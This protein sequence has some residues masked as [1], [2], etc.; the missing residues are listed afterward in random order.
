MTSTQ[1]PECG[2]SGGRRSWYLIASVVTVVTSAAAQPLPTP[3]Q[4]APQHVPEARPER[5]VVPAFF[6]SEG[7]SFVSRSSRLQVRLEQSLVIFK[8]G[9]AAVT[10]EFS[11]PGRI[12]R[13]EAGRPASGWANLMSG[14]DRGQWRRELPIVNDVVYR[15]IYEGINLH[16]L[17]GSGA[18]KSEFHVAAGA[19]P[20]RIRMRYRGA[21]GV[22][23]AAGGELV[24]TAGSGEMREEAPVAYQWIDGSP[25]AVASR[26]RLEA[27][28]TVGFE[29]GPFDAA[30]GLII[31]PVMN[32][33]SF[34]G[35]SRID[36]ATSV[37]TDS[38]GNVYVAGWSESSDL[39]LT[40]PFGTFRGS[41]D[42]FVYKLNAAG[43]SVVYA[44][45]LGGSGDDRAQ[46]IAVDSLGNAWV[47]GYTTSSNFPTVLP[48]QGSRSG[49][50]DVFVARINA[51]GSG[52]LMSTYYGGGSNDEANAIAVDSFNQAYV[53]GE[54]SSS[55]FPTRFPFQTSNRGGT[56][57][58]LFKIGVS[59]QITFS[60]YVGGA[61]EDS[62]NAVA[63]SPVL[64]PYVAGCTSSKN[65]PTRNPTQA[66][67]A[68][69]QDGFVI[70]FDGDGAN[71][72][73]GTYFGGNGGGLGRT[74][75]INAMAVDTFGNS[76]VTGVT[77]STNLPLLNAF[78]STRGGSTYD[79]FVAKLDS[80]GVRV[81][82]SYLGGR[83]SD[84]PTAIQVDAS[85]R[86]YV[87]GYT[88][89]NNFPVA[90]PVQAT[91][92]GLY[93]AFLV[94]VST[95]GNALLFGTYLGG[96]SSDMAAGLAFRSGVAT[97]TG[98]TASSDFPVT[99]PIQ[100]GMAGAVD[101]WLA[102]VTF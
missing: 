63:I 58:F 15:D 68:G 47:T 54:T 3:R 42:A 45:F 38:S 7:E 91:F 70:R 75:C 12:G 39:P 9:E 37:A 66:V 31:D 96:G 52:L 48:L 51:A 10:L 79:G 50:R 87:A 83:G 73:F 62:V 77:S 41:V 100:S 18:V 56:D 95:A 57:G 82:S 25:V 64:T 13:P 76:Y 98:V 19:D 35:G 61:G 20:N 2:R 29:V 36:N 102:K 78:Q 11:S 5:T 26:F 1:R 28:D 6:V 99:V 71:Q 16:F 72:I 8:V 23:L 89:S 59:G 93:D 80:D 101:G 4:D 53:G 24:I 46:A 30:Y 43:T 67:L 22:R 65:F 14:A 92:G 94:Q 74:E 85:R 17:A 97:V 21:T 84:F 69:G 88:S 60:T 27:D 32:T 40:A 34:L 33:S 55:N 49:G 81:Y 86:A 90:S 44:T